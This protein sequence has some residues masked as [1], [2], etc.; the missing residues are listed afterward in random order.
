MMSSSNKSNKSNIKHMSVGCCIELEN[1]MT[2]PKSKQR[3][4]IETEYIWFGFRVCQCKTEPNQII[5]Y[6]T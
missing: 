2:E 5:A 3:N 4:R 6:M 1:Q